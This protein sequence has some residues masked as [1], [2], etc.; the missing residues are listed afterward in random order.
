MTQF[1]YAFTK[2]IFVHFLFLAFALAWVKCD[3]ERTA[4]LNAENIK[5]VRRSVRVDVVEMPKYT[6]KELK[7]LQTIMDGPASAPAVDKAAAEGAPAGGSDTIFEKEKENLSFTDLLKD[8]SKKNVEKNKK[9][10]SN[11]SESSK[12]KKKVSLAVKNEFKELL[13]AGNIIKKGGALVGENTQGDLAVEEFSLYITKLP[14]LIR[15]H[16]KLPSYL[17]DKGLRC[18]IRLYLNQVGNVLK[19]EI[20]ESSGVVEFDEKAIEAIRASAPFPELSNLVQRKALNGEILL[21]F[22]L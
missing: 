16:W 3:G 11:S 1:Q 15:P 19:T 21:G 13:N 8:I 4:E 20:F 10:N 22:P 6:I 5:L 9:T 7:K 17:I 12:A 2:S 18:R 14:D